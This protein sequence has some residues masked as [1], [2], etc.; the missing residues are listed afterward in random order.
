MFFFQ[1]ARLS[2][3]GG[4]KSSSHDPP[5]TPSSSFGSRAWFQ[6]STSIPDQRFVLLLFFF[7]RQRLVYFGSQ[8]MSVVVVVVPAWV[9]CMDGCLSCSP[10]R[11]C[12][13]WWKVADA[14]CSPS[15]FSFFLWVWMSTCDVDVTHCAPCDPVLL[16][17]RLH[18]SERMLSPLVCRLRAS[19]DTCFPLSWN[20]SRV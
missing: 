16:D 18:A 5:S 7:Y 2:H 19:A 9:H 1:Q 20:T 12:C 17:L 4:G 3:Y 13:A 6:F 11:T 15:P 10:L 14:E 8:H